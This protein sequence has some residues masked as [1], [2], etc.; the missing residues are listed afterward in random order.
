MTERL[1]P[2]AVHIVEDLAGDWCRLDDRI[3]AIFT[4]IT[5]LAHVDDSAVRLMSAPGIGPIISSAT[6]GWHW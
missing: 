6:G 1:T 4:E 5:E 2:R 3:E